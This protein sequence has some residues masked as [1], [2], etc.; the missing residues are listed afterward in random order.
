[1]QYSNTKYTF[2]VAITSESADIGNSS[3]LYLSQHGQKVL[4][5]SETEMSAVTFHNSSINY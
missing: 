3:L 4:K 1:M 2:E 5:S